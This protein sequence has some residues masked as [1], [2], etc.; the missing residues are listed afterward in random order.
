MKSKTRHTDA[1]K[2]CI[3][4]QRQHRYVQRFLA[5]LLGLILV[6]IS[7]PNAWAKWSETAGP[8]N[9]RAP[10]ATGTLNVMFPDGTAVTN[11]A[12]VSATL[13]P[14]DFGISVSALTLQDL[15]GDTGLSSSLDTAA[16]TWVW[17]YNNVELTAAQLAAEFSTNFSGKTLTVAASVPVTVSSLT[18]APTTGNPSTLSSGTYTVKVPVSPPVVRVNGASFAMN[19]GFPK[20]GFSQAQFQ[21][22]MNGTSAAGNS[23]YTFSPA[24]PAPWVTVNP[25][26]GVVK[27]TGVPAAAQT[28]N[29]T[30]TDNRGGPATPFSFR[31]GTWFI[32]NDNIRVTPANADSYCAS[33]TGYATPSYLKMTNA[34]YRENGTRA[35][36]GRLWD[37]W[38]N[39]REYNSSWMMDNGYWALEPDGSLRFG[40]YLTNGLLLSHSLTG[41]Y[42][43]V[44][45]RTL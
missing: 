22:W 18:G 14:T 8:I 12:V 38:G 21:F 4:A 7:A 41:Y 37:E 17:K 6:V 39:L 29:I 28:V 31:V 24:N 13:K 35:A 19:S 26:T 44:C 10:T 5:M 43:V 3:E 23:N 34:K 25:T 15:D 36:D 33:K 45:S 20:T 16:A 9:G 32:N 27:F 42:Q 2:P 40:V 1:G 11:N 30:I